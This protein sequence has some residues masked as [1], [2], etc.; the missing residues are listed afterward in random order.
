M[1]YFHIL[2]FLEFELPS[3]IMYQLLIYIQL[4]LGDR[5]EVM[6]LL[7]KACS[8][9]RHVEK[10][11]ICQTAT[12]I[13]IHTLERSSIRSLCNFPAAGIEITDILKSQLHHSFLTDRRTH[14]VLRQSCRKIRDPRSFP[15]QVHI[16][17]DIGIPR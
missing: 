16:F 10:V 3:G 6:L 15:D 1:I 4:L 11:D 13:D 9:D 12:L 2:S 5:P 17:G 8:K 7:E 14:L